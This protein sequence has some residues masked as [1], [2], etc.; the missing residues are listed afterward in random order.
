MVYARLTPQR[1]QQNAKDP[2]EM[3]VIGPNTSI[4]K[5]LGFIDCC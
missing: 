2:V 5:K 4:I 1:R 3:T